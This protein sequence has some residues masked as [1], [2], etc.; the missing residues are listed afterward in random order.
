VVHEATGSSAAHV[1]A[2]SFAGATQGATGTSRT[3]IKLAFTSHA[4]TSDR[5]PRVGQ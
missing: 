3:T 1:A 2:H 4:A 5:K